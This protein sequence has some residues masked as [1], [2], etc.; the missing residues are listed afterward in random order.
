MQ[1]YLCNTRATSVILV[2]VDDNEVLLHSKGDIPSKNWFIAMGSVKLK[3]DK[4]IEESES[5][6]KRAPSIHFLEDDDGI[7]DQ[8]NRGLFTEN[9]CGL[10]PLTSDIVYGYNINSYKHICVLRLNNK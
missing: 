1:I 5:D 10:I 2:S 3:N 4:E 9:V 6:D 8:Y 7:T